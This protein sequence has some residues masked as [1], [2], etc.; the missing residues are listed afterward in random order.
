MKV[1]SPNYYSEFKCIGGTCIDTCCAG[2]EVDVDKE[3]SSY[4]KSVEGEFGDKLRS[5]LIDLPVEDQF[6]LTESGRCPFLNDCNLCDI[7]TNLGEE[8]LC[9]TCTNFPRHITE[10]GSTK[11]IGIS[12]SCPTA[13]ELIMSRT[14]PISFV[15]VNDDSQVN[16]VNDID[17]DFYFVLKE[18]RDLAYRIVQDRNVDIC[19]R[20]ALFLS[21]SKALEKNK[22]KSSSLRKVIDKYSDDEYRIKKINKLKSKAFNKFKRKWKNV[23]G[24]L[25]VF[26]SLEHIKKE[27]VSILDKLFDTVEAVSGIGIVGSS[28]FED[29][30]KMNIEYEHLLVYYIFRYFLTAVFDDKIYEKAALAVTALNMQRLLADSIKLTG[31]E[32]YF[33]MRITLMRLY[34][35][36]TEHSEE[37]LSVL[38]DAFERDKCFS[39]K[40]L[41][42][43]LYN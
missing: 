9:D 25:L 31:N 2:W 23:Y 6:K 20:V 15:T 14:E 35:K 32:P 27:W 13:A 7:F 29:N 26:D 28:E 38:Y 8:H 18:A 30:E 37:N 12:L 43:V 4:Y 24:Q 21:F 42:T 1:I 11:E 34:S 3:S 5:L 10:Y 40:A 33:D 17:P 19:D 16:S 41:L 39:F 22:K 36:E